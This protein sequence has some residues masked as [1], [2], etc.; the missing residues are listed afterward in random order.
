MKLAA[1]GDKPEL[2]EQAMD[3]ANRA[4]AARIAWSRPQVLL[5]EICRAQHREDEA[6]QHYMRAVK[7]GDRDLEL[8]RL[9]LQMLYD[10]Q[11]Y[12]EADQ[13][14][15]SLDSGQTAL[16]FDIENIKTRILAQWGPFDQ[17]WESANRSY[18]PESSDYS[19]HLWHGREL[20]LLVRR[21]QLEGHPDELPK[22]AEQAEQALRRARQMA[23]KVAD[24]H[25]ALVQL[26]VATGQRKKAKVAAAD[27]EDSLPY[28]VSPLAMG[29]IYE[30]LGQSEKARESWEK[31]V[32]RNPA[33]QAVLL[34]ADFHL[35][36]QNFSRA[37]ELVAPLLG[38]DTQ[39]SEIDRLAARR[40]QASLLASQG[41]PK[42]Q[43]A[44]ELVDRNLASPLATVKDKRLKVRLL[45]ADPGRNHGPEVLALARSLVETG[46]A[47][48]D[49][50]DR[51][52]LAQLYLAR[53]VWEG[54]RG[55][56]ERLLNGGQSNP[57]YLSAWVRMLLDRDQL[58][59]AGQWLERLERLSASAE[60]VAFRAEL[61]FRLKKWGEVPGF[62]DAYLKAEPKERL[63]RTLFAARLL[64][65]LGGRFTETRERGLAQSYFDQARAWYEACAEQRPG[66]EMLLAGFLAR[67]GKIDEALP[68]LERFGGKAAPAELRNA[69]VFLVRCESITPGQL[70]QVEKVLDEAAAAQKRPLPLLN[71]M[72]VLKIS[73]GRSAEAEDV[74][75]RTIEAD[76][77]DFFACNNLGLLLALSGNKLD[78]A[79]A[80]INHAIELAGPLPVLLD[81]RAVVHIARN[82]PQQ[83]LDDLS[84]IGSEKTDPVWLF[85]KA[86]ALML[87]GQ[88][89]QAGAVLVEARQKGLTRAMIDPPERPFFDQ[90][91]KQLSNR[92]PD[93]PI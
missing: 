73:Q 5:G 67:R 13:V 18:D 82:E 1:G 61:M 72:M 92:N 52:Q 39:L 42:L 68:L 30:A 4:Q 6:L 33:P 12:Q 53:G 62:L 20:I 17:A 81:S 59:D 40:V 29:Y 7:A 57:G 74:C 83:A 16:T 58:N 26:L 75:R 46:G 51:F 25:V 50:N 10:R 22:I 91:Q 32:Q 19:H 43:E 31:A 8:I 45:L 60:T 70:Q 36:R 3:Y 76:P 64:E 55:Q 84:A 35:R 54:C 65:D 2:L 90:L 14:L 93:K 28:A 88:G 11:D 23:P 89:E 21:A 86:R 77:K 63:E 69:A 38:A 56:M 44:I 34:L 48:P 24:C 85:H 66:S 47:E 80:T 49:P 9:L 87:A 79:L 71:A 37:A 78:E 15:Q 41:Y 27:A